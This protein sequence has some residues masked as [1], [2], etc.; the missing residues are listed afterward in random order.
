[1]L[2]AYVYVD[3]ANPPSEI[4]LAWNTTAG[5]W[6]HG[7]YWGVN[8]IPY[9]AEG[10]ASR[11]FMGP[12]PPPGQWWRLEVPASAVGLEGA[13]LQGMNFVLHGGSAAFDYSGA[14]RQ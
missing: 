6:Q 2:F 7:A 5:D 11:R 12:M 14:A 10:T 9:G 13:T 3:P 1:M 4:M 8:L